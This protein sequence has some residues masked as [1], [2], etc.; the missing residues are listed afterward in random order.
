MAKMTMHAAN[1]ETGPGQPV[2]GWTVGRAAENYRPL[3]AGEKDDLKK[4]P[5]HLQIDAAEAEMVA[6]LGYGAVKYGPGNWRTVEDAANRYYDAA[7]RHLRSSRRG[8]VLDPE[9]G[10]FSLAS[11]ACCVHFLLALELE[12]HP[13]L[14]AALEDRYVK[15]LEVARRLKEKREAEKRERLFLPGP[16]IYTFEW[17][18]RNEK[19]TVVDRGH[20]LTRTEAGAAAAAS[21]FTRKVASPSFEV[22]DIFAEGRAEPRK[23]RAPKKKNRRR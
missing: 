6:V 5:F 23:T 22:R 20:A 17:L 9:H 1:A 11:A 8:E 19:G 18:V 2:T 16:V 21:A 12:K 15:S 10:L 3:K 13:E 14:E 7:R 4:L